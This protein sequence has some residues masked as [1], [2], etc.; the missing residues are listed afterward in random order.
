[1]LLLLLPAF[2]SLYAQEPGEIRGRAFDAN[3]S[4]LSFANVTA[5]QGE[6]I[7][8][9]QADGDGRFVVK[10]LVPGVW[11]MEISS[12]GATTLRMTGVLVQPGRINVLND[13]TL[14]A[15]DTLKEFILVDYVRPLVEFDHPERM[16]LLASEIKTNPS[17]K[18]LRTLIGNE[19]PGVTKAPNGD[20]LFFRGSRSE[21]MASYIDGVR[22]PGAVPS[23]PSAAISSISV[24]TGGLP[25]RYGDVTGGVVVI[26][27]KTYFEIYEERRALEDALLGT[28]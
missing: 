14:A 9:A 10:P 19:F 6:R 13:L 28:P 25:A 12:V 2:T 24:Y 8:G 11:T 27:T 3:G 20:G 17:V 22:V 16:S 18:N 21:N 5:T 4:P 23:I 26:E 1:M 7:V 15:N